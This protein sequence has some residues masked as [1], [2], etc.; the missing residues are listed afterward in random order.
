MRIRRATVAM[1]VTAT[2]AAVGIGV[3]GRR[4]P[5][6]TTPPTTTSDRR[7]GST[8]IPVDHDDHRCVVGVDVERRP[9]TTATTTTTTPSTTT[10]TTPK[11][12]TTSG[13]S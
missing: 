5:R 4:L 10:T 2:V 12:T 7:T 6:P 11:A 8:A 9:A 13:Q 1:G 3:A